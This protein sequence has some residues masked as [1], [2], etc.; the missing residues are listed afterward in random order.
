MEHSVVGKPLPRIDGAAKATGQ[1]KYTD[2][3]T[4]P[5]M[6]HGKI[7]RSPHPHAR[8]VNI[9]TSRA[10]RLPGVKAVVTGKDTAGIRY[11]YVDGL[12]PDMYPLSVDK[13]RY[14]GDEVAAVAAIEEEIAEEALEL[15]KIDYELLP[16]I[17]DPEEAMKDDA[18]QVHEGFLPSPTMA[19]EDM[20]FGKKPEPYKVSNN[21]C[22]TFSRS[23][24]DIEKGF[25]ESDY[26]HADRFVIPTTAHCAMEPHIALANFDSSGSLQV[27][28]SH[29]GYERKRQY[30]AATLGMPLNKVRVL[31]AYVGGGFGGKVMLF[32]CEFL[33]AFLS[34][35]TG[36]PV[37]IVMSREEVFAA[38]QGDQRMT[39]DLKTGIKKDGTLVAQEIKVLN[40][41][42]AY[43]GSSLI[44]MRLAY[45]KI[46]P[47]Y[48]IPNVKCE[49]ICVYTNKLVCGPKRGHG[50]PQV[51]FGIESQFDM[52]AKELGIDPLELRLKNARKEGETL[53][54]GDRL[55][56]CGLVECIKK[57]AESAGW[58][59]KYGKKENHGMGIGVSAAQSSTE[60]Y[61][62]GSSAVVKINP[63]GS[64]TLFTGAVETGQG[65]DTA[66]CQ[67]VAEE[68]GLALED[69]ILVSADSELCPTD[70]GNFIMGGVY[71]TGEAVR[72]AAADARRQFLE[73]ASR[74]LE[75]GVE[76]LGVKNRSIY[77]KENPE[78]LVSFSTVLKLSQRDRDVIIGKGYRKAGPKMELGFF[79]D[80]YTFTVAVAEVEID[81]ETGV[82]S[83]LRIILAHDGGFAINPLNVE[84][85]I[86]GQVVMG[87][88]DLLYEEVLIKDGQIINASFVDYKIP[89]SLDDMEIK[90]ISVDTFDPGGPF[91]AKEAGECAR[92]PLLPAVSNAIYNAIGVRF[93]ELPLTPDKILTAIRPHEKRDI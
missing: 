86:E 40:D 72:L 60:I 81:K 63:D 46:I 84:G 5:Q 78:K 76:E 87:Q 51:A 67:I 57:A 18:Q 88:G 4:L 6:L 36:R 35:K 32:S 12:P 26:I 59:D 20:G 1:A 16:A 39:I 71:V 47:I 48:N 11:G 30:L 75:I 23:H 90:L 68:M 52:I 9:D 28:I 77:I 3:L 85:Q 21:I 42:G 58:W 91:G 56:S 70:L 54:N 53:P 7:L 55:T 14:V 22:A 49:G 89:L 64:V 31:K 13:V 2:D 17:F 65:S 44:A 45:S 34:R 79:S 50:T 38:T 61:P 92:S 24:G 74:V 93:K 66:M 62:Y 27:W 15:I 25:K 41:S 19:W 83:L 80:A 43:R 69:V 82:I 10:E 37:K 73:E 8:I 33:A 29:M